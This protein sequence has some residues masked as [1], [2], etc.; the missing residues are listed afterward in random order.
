MGIRSRIRGQCCNDDDD[1]IFNRSKILVYILISNFAF[2]GLLGGGSSL[3]L[4]HDITLP[5]TGVYPGFEPQKLA[6]I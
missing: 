3:L 5:G 2:L 4:P 1:R 6:T